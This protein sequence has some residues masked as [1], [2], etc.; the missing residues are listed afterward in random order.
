MPISMLIFRLRNVILIVWGMLS[1]FSHCLT[2]HLL[3]P[4]L[5]CQF[6]QSVSVRCV[7]C[8]PCQN[9]YGCQ[10]SFDTNTH[11][12]MSVLSFI[13]ES[14]WMHR[15]KHTCVHTHTCILACTHTHSLT[16]TCT[17][18]HT[19]THAHM[20]AH[21]HAHTHFHTHTQTHRHTHTHTHSNTHTHTHTHTQ[22]H[23]LV[24]IEKLLQMLREPSSTHR[25]SLMLLSTV[26]IETLVLDCLAARLHW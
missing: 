5:L 13:I 23:T 17:H 10:E 19:R 18:T 20:H 15:H 3:Y 12:G 25:D 9:V 22:T 6:A 2:H 11:T 16:H 21:T 4:R 14:V 26:L 8:F 1:S 7:V 24:W